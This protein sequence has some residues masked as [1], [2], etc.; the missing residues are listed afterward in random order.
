LS[1]KK[2]IFY[3]SPFLVPIATPKAVI[4][5]A[6]AIQKYSTEYSCSIINL[7]GEFN[8][9]K[10]DIEKKKINLINH[11]FYRIKS[12]LP[13]NGKIKS[14]FSYIIIFLLS[15]FPL[16]N[17]ISKEKPDYIVVQLITSLPMILVLI[18]NFKT[19]FI[20][21]ISG[22]PRVTFF[23]KLLWKMALKKFYLVTCP[24]VATMEY[25]KSLNIIND[26]KIKVLY[27]PIIEVKKIKEDMNKKN[28]FKYENYFLAAGRLTKQ[29]NFLFLCKA[30]HRAVLK[31]P[32]LKL[33]IA[34]EGEDKKKIGDYILKN[35]LEKNIILIGHVR[36]IYPVMKEAEAF[37]LSS[38][39]EDPGFVIIEAAFC[40]TVII[41]SNC[42]PGPK[43][44]IKD[45]YNGLL[46]ETNNI[47]DFIKK[48]EIMI[49]L[50]NKKRLVLNNLKMINKFT[51]FNHYNDFIKLLS[52]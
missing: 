1:L 22:L 30:F 2:K 36:N 35:D 29:K 15:F 14:R 41:S 3:W 28:S 42:E 23:R 46:F 45:N 43:E 38:L 4:N 50:T 40:K 47:S 27:D 26:E 13:F 49:N 8:I 34:G 6:N 51:Q 21:R 19:K 48:F 52:K 7:F 12:F 44:I 11:F 25:I 37:I 17:L 31:H 16:K 39:W 9:F 33:L 18:F 20:L 10:D 32:N 24:T 5:S